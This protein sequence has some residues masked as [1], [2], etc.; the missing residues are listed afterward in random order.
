M[1]QFYFAGDLMVMDELGY[2][3]FKDR[4][5]DTFR[6]VEDSFLTFPKVVNYHWTNLITARPVLRV[7]IFIAGE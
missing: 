6:L 4:C 1:I 2:I 5:G 7:E 3:Y